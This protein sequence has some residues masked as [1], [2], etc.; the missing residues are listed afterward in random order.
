MFLLAAIISF[1]T[2]FSKAISFDSRQMTTA[3]KSLSQK[4]RLFVVSIESWDN[5]SRST[6]V[7]FVT[8]LNVNFLTWFRFFRFLKA[9]YFCWDLE[10]KSFFAERG[11]RSRALSFWF[12]NHNQFLR[13]KVPR[14]HHLRND[15]LTRIR[16]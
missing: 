5:S 8:F 15:A 6:W 1:F 11:I 9:A 4:L 16:A 7:D 12:M 13:Q 10:K 2:F 14:H 3:L